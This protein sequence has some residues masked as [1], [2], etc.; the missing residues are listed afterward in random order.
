MVGHRLETLLRCALPAALL[1]AS[2]ATPGATLLPL[3]VEVR[4]R[5]VAPGEP[6][7]LI[8]TAPQ[9]LE[10]LSAS[11]LGEELELTR[12]AAAD[13]AERWTAW[14][15]VPLDHRGGTEAVELSGRTR[16][17]GEAGGTLALT[18]EHKEFPEERLSV[19]PGYVNPPA[20]V[21]RRLQAER[22]K[23]AAVYRAREAPLEL[24]TPFVRPVEGPPTSI[25]GMRRFFND[26]PRSPHPG[27]DLRAAT[28]TPVHCSGPGRVALAENLYYSG[29]TVIVD[30]GGGL[31]TL[32]AH[33]SEILV[34][35]GSAARAGQLIGKAGATGR[36]TGP[37]L[38][39]GAKIGD[40]PFDPTALLDP[41]LFD[42]AGAGDASAGSR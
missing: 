23:L 25:F 3:E 2:G 4:A 29:N 10:S 20:D 19:A 18:V 34:E 15:L 33:L 11:F 17:G 28:G 27:L 8:V 32:Y 9:P 40:R 39:W 7:R 26:E 1:L 14:T 13:G 37:H 38:H 30:H 12:V 42:A 16:S 35:E 22:A 31:F 6:L 41:E 5:C 36:V 21:E 24:D